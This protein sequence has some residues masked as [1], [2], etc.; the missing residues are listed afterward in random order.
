M[1]RIYFDHAAT[2]F[3]KGEGV[4]EEMTH[5]MREVG[6]NINRGSYEDA[7]ETAGAVYDTREKLC[8]LFDFGPLPTMVKNVIFTANIT[9]AMNIIL[10]GYLKDGDHVLVSAMEHNAVMRPLVQLEKQ[11]N[12]TFGRIPCSMAGELYVEKI[13]K[14]IQ[15]NTK[16]IIMT[17]A[18]NICGTVLPMQKVGEIAH[19]NGLVFIVDSAQTAGVFPI[20]MRKMHID[21][22]AFTGHKGLLGPQG[23]GGFV[24]TDDMAAQ[25]E[26]VITGGTGSIS[27]SEETPAFLPDK[28]EAG[29]LNLPGIIGLSAG[30]N[31]I[32]KRGIE[33]IRNQEKMLTEYFLEQ[34]SKIMGIKL[35]GKLDCVD[36]NAVVSIQ[37]TFMDEAELAFLLD[38]QYHI[39]T[40]VGMHCAPGAHKTLGTFPE[41]TVRFSFGYENTKEEIDY[42]IKAIQEIISQQRI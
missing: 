30:L 12:I 18:S 4:I 42:A 32:E 10:K 28:F 23:I 1:S 29:T 13:E 17:H 34:I 21:A 14:M 2:S 39:Q 26:P 6:V 5:Y 3:P 20:S 35:I 15:K 11:R 36:R 33:K 16:A 9:Y 19:N 41:G 38:S 31:I 24:I 40:R 27:D 7:Y 25:M 22:L 8:R 37:T